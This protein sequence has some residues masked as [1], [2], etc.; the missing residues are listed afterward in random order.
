MYEI[1]NGFEYA[2]KCYK[3]ANPAILNLKYC[4]SCKDKDKI[5]HERYYE[6]NKEKIKEKDKQYRLNNPDKVKETKRKERN[7]NKEYYD[8]YHK[9]YYENNKI[10]ILK[11]N[12]K[13]Q[14][15]KSKELKEYRIKNKDKRYANSA[16]YRAKKRNAFISNVN[17]KKIFERDN[18]VCQICKK[19]GFTFIDKYH[20]LYLTIDHII[21]ISKGGLHCPENVQTAHFRCNSSK[22]DKLRMV[23]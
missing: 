13:Y 14:K 11:R 19:L 9:E 1:E 17:K 6:K 8:E 5:K 2:Q 15:L 23:Y 18:Y 16:N 4:Q 7:K 3:C 10:E 12:K 20:P 21:P 22:G